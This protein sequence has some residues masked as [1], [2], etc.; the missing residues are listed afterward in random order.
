VTV[1]VGVIGAGMIG[2]DHIRRLTDVITGAESWRHRSRPRSASRSPVVWAPCGGLRIDVIAAADVDAVLSPPG[3]RPIRARP[4]CDRG[5]QAVFCEKPLATAAR[6]ACGSS[7]GNGPRPTACPGR[8]MRRYD[9]GYQEMKHILDSGEIGTP[10]MVHLHTGTRPCRS[11]TTRP[12]PYRTPP[13]RDRRAPLLLDDEIVAV[14]SSPR[15]RPV[16]IRASPRP[17][18]H[19]VRNRRG[20]AHRLEVLSTASTAT[21]SSARP[22]VNVV[23]FGFL[24]RPG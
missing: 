9:S 16:S 6:S 18:D 21:T 8:F 3:G 5:G 13:P 14:Q 12:W 10:L 2:Q 4:R 7:G 22:W 20:S 1:R 24:T 17:A 19:V 15:A 23:S 11:R